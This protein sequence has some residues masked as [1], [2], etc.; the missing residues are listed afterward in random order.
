M[1]KYYIVAES[2][3]DIPP[4][5]IKK[6]DIRVVQMHVEMAEKDYLDKDVSLDEL[7]GCFERTGKI[8][9][10]AGANPHQYVEVFNE[11]KKENPGA[12]ILHLCYSAQLS[13]SFQS[14]VIAAEGFNNL[15]NIDTKNV[16]M[17]QGLVVVMAAEIIEQEPDIQPDELVR[18][19][20]EISQ[21][22]RFTFI[23]GDIEYLRAGGRVSNAQYLGAR[24][25]RVKPLIEVI[26]GLM[27]PTGKY[28]GTK[29]EIIRKAMADYFKKYKVE[30]EKM[31]FGYTYKIE[32]DIKREIEILAEAAGVKS[33]EWV[34]AGGVI[35]SHAGPGG[36]GI[37]G[38][39]K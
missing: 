29:K 6:H 9:K 32:E 33:F 7:I 17:G 31:Y 10:T 3:A 39:E 13:V 18:R 19:I 25:L 14:S 16:T 26:G 27:L 37:L 30:K 21:Q 20:E 11:I 15:Y 22:V 2:G 12:I 34:V 5:I 38:I 23:P 24:L 35:T 1:R 4:E 28:M 36:I 8:P